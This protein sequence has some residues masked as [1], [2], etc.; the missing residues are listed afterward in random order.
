MVFVPERHYTDHTRTCRVYSDM[1]TGDWWWAVQVRKPLYVLI[2]ALTSHN[3]RPL[4][5]VSL[6]QQ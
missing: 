2:Q 6:E 5:P 4:N 3:R 1:H